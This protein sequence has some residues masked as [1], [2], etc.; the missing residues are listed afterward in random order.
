MA[1]KLKNVSP[2]TITSNLLF[3]ERLAVNHVAYMDDDAA[4][5]ALSSLTYLDS[6]GA[7]QPRLEE[8]LESVAHN[9]DIRTRRTGT[10]KAAESLA[11]TLATMKPA[12]IAA[13]RTL[14]GVSVTPVAVAA[15]RALTAADSGKTLECTA[16]ITLTV[17]ESLPADFR[18]TVVNAA[19]GGGTITLD[20]Q[21]AVNINGSTNN[22]L[23]TS[24]AP[25]VW[26]LAR[27]IAANNFTA[28]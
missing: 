18:V 7:S 5:V 1:K 17:P 21:G 15:S 11:A 27:N 22:A 16:G 14:L 6:N 25:K 23:L 2:S 9:V 20:P 24:V 13:L 4:A 26:Y 3:G 28:A 19:A 8:V 10:E 12:Q